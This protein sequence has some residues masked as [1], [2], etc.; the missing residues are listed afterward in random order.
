MWGESRCVLPTVIASA[1]LPGSL[2]VF[3]RPVFVLALGGADVAVPGV[4]GRDDDHDAAPDQPIH[5]DAERALAAGE[6]LRVEIVA[7][8]QVHAVNAQ[9]LRIVVELL[10]H[11][12]QRA[13]DV[14]DA[15]GA[16]RRRAPSG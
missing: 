8:A 7:D 13:H 4:S 10:A 14:A 2:I 5:L 1:A 9:H 12:D 16:V 15:T 6:H 11:I 3:D